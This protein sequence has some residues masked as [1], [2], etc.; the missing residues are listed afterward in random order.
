MKSAWVTAPRTVE[1]KEMDMPRVTED[2]VLIR[3]KSAGVCGSD[4]GLFSGEHPFRVPPAMLGHEMAGE[5]VE[6][7]KNVTDYKPGDRV[8]FN[9]V[10]NCG[11]CEEC[12]DDI[13][14]LCLDRQIAGANGS[15]IQGTFAEYI[16]VPE[17][18]LCKFENHVSYDC[19]MMI[20]PLSVAVHALKRFNGRKDSM[21]IYG[22][23]VIGLCSLLYARD[24][25]DKR[26]YCV[27]RGAFNREMA[28][29]LLR[30]LQSGGCE[31][32]WYEGR[33]DHHQC[34]CDRRHGRSSDWYDVHCQAG[35]G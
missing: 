29:K 11:K 12:A 24:M 5:V 28:M 21:L 31:A 8:A 32:F 26:I 19:G 33:P 20:E 30:G 18:H 13:G 23:G 34:L 7:G 2:G 35:S 9:P 17:S 10:V 14:N 16:N 22:T 27:N 4:I 25:G 1:M 3:I 6:T 15:S